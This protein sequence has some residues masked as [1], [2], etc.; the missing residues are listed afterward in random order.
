MNDDPS[1]LRALSRRLRAADYRVETL[2]RRRKSSLVAAR[3]PAG[4]PMLD[5]QMPGTGGLELQEAL[6]QAEEPL[7]VIFLTAYG[8]RSSAVHTMKQGAVDFSPSRFEGMSCSMRCSG[9]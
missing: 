1:F 4:C 5:F 8:E 7:P 3:T 2:V 6:A 9:R